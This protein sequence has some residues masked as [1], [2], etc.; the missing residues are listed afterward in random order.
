MVAS[1]CPSSSP[2]DEAI[3]CCG[4]ATPIAST[5]AFKLHNDPNREVHDA[6]FYSFLAFAVRKQKAATLMALIMSH[7]PA[8]TETP[9]TGYAVPCLPA[10]LVQPPILFT[11]EALKNN[12]L[13]AETPYVIHLTS[14]HDFGPVYSHRYF[15]C[16]ANLQE[17]WIE[18]SLVQWFAAGEPFK[19]KAEKWDIKCQADARFFR[20]TLRPNLSMRG[21]ESRLYSHRKSFQYVCKWSFTFES[22]TNLEIPQKPERRNGAGGSDGGGG[23][24][25]CMIVWGGKGLRGSI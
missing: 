20:M 7:I 23:D 11:A 19:M 14:R 4:S 10:P 16:P 12:P 24:D 6:I 25:I 22:F 8:E 9:T 18:I 21:F 2:P 1:S 15:V 17:D 3:F 5:N 13:T